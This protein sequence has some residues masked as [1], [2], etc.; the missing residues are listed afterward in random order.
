MNFLARKIGAW[1]EDMDLANSFSE[2]TTD[3]TVII[4]DNIPPK[5][6]KLL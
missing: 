2:G 6:L 3:D 4:Y 1:E 5:Y